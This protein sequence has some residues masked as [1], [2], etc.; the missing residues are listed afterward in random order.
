MTKDTRR[1][2]ALILVIISIATVAATALAAEVCDCGGK[3]FYKYGAWEQLPTYH[4]APHLH[5][6]RTVHVHC[7]KCSFSCTYTERK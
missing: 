1:I 2:I 7:N 3:L 5:Y 6:K 4:G